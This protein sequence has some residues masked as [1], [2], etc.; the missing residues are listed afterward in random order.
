MTKNLTQNRQLKAFL[1]LILLVSFGLY[2]CAKTAVKETKKATPEKVL[3]VSISGM[4]TP[5]ETFDQY[6]AMLKYLAEKTGR[7]YVLI[8]RKTYAEVNELVK[9]K[10]V[11]LAFICSG[12]YLPAK[13]DC[14]A[15]LL[16]VPVVAGRPEYYS[17]IIVAEDSGLT[18]F[19]QLKGR[20]FAFTD[21][22]SN[23]GKLYP[24]FLI[25]QTGQTPGTF[26]SK[27]IFTYNHDN[28]IKAVQQKTVEGAA[29]D[30]LIYDYL[31][32]KG[33]AATSG[34]RILMKSPA[35]GIPP[36]IV[37][38]DTDP[39]LKAELKSVLLGLDQDPKGA[40]ILRSLLIDRF[41][42]SDDALYQT[43]ADMES[44]VRERGIK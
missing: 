17:D 12:A 36:V 6:D 37:N 29:V 9:N 41:I 39:A 43:I 40:K 2:G 10:Q 27:Y 21:E 13:R 15:E 24:T 16:A 7:K 34:V 32:A 5:K 31:A 11:D 35:F 1:F 14:N 4:V 26:F 42:E 28:S 38:K 25:A 19:S 23:T 22:L 30:S 8:Q 20:S 18:D 3:R 33:P 44:Y